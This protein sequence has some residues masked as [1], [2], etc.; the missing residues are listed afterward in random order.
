MNLNSLLVIFAVIGAS[1]IFTLADGK[2]FDNQLMFVLLTFMI[3]VLYKTNLLNNL[4]SSEEGFIINEIDGTKIGEFLKGQP[5]DSSERI[6]YNEKADEINKNLSG[7]SNEIK[8]LNEM[9]KMNENTK[10]DSINKNKD[11]LSSL[12]IR[13]IQTRQNEDLNRLSDEIQK[14]KN[15]L[16]ETDIEK[17]NKSYHKIPVYSSCVISNADGSITEDEPN[18]S[19]NIISSDNNVNSNPKNPNGTGSSTS[20]DDMLNFLKNVIENGVN[21]NLS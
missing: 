5:T 15:L 16:T 9:M 3:L 17:N 11:Y 1:Y 2:Q 10:N 21:V 13:N 12:D 4:I 6:N 20:N 7:L 19:K 14:A 8:K 18:E